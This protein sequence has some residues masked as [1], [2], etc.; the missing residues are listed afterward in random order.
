MRHKSKNKTRSLFTLSLEMTRL[1]NETRLLLVP[2]FN[3]DIYGTQLIV[4]LLHNNYACSY[5]C[6]FHQLPRPLNCRKTVHLWGTELRV[7]E[8]PIIT[9]R[10]LSVLILLEPPRQQSWRKHILSILCIT[11]S[12]K[13]AV[14]MKLQVQGLVVKQTSLPQTVALPQEN[15]ATINEHK[16]EHGE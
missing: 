2:C 1:V 13:I 10:D 8:N 11:V 14:T 9:M 5:M 6:F 15:W 3:S 7:R 12:S 16:P 4:C